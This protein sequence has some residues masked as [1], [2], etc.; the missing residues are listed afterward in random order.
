MQELSSRLSVWEGS[1]LRR[2]Q[3]SELTLENLVRD[4]ESLSMLG[5]WVETL[6]RRLH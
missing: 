2:K 3:V 6:S 5:I 1:C 4:G